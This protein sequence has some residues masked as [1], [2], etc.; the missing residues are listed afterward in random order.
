MSGSFVVMDDRLRE[1]YRA[2]LAVNAYAERARLAKEY[3]RSFTVAYLPGDFS[4]QS[5][6]VIGE[7]GIVIKYT[8]RRKK[9]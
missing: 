4:I 9:A 2:K 6:T 3:K 5:Q 1:V 8:Q 7:G